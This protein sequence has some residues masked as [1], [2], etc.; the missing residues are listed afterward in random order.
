MKI[1]T[2]S[3]V[4]AC[5]LAICTAQAPSRGGYGQSQSPNPMQLLMYRA[6]DMNMFPAL[7]LSGHL[8][9]G[10]GGMGSNM[11]LPFLFM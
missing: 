7:F 5:V 3:I 2:L 9:G 10:G 1:V 4:A 6:L 11:F 8:G